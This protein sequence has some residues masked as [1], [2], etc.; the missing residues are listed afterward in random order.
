M[1]RIVL[2]FNWRQFS[3]PS[4]P[5]PFWRAI[6]LAEFGQVRWGSRFGQNTE[7]GHF[8]WTS[9]AYISG[10]CR[11]SG[12]FWRLVTLLPLQRPS[13]LLQTFFFLCRQAI[14]FD[15]VSVTP[16]EIKSISRM[17]IVIVFVEL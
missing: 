1:Q 6:P 13:A 12:P 10:M 17:V 16:V 3:S 7:S 4:T 15:R 2:L 8:L 9:A 5:R 14:V 11:P